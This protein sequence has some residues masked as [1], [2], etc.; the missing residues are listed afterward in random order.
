MFLIFHRL[1][2]QLS[3]VFTNLCSCLTI[4]DGNKCLTFLV[5]K[6]CGARGSV[7]TEMI[8]GELSGNVSF[9]IV[10]GMNAVACTSYLVPGSRFV[11]G[12][13]KSVVL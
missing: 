10:S 9:V 12:Y 11:R 2:A 3:K 7:Y 4:L 5:L 6:F 13:L 1:P 8:L